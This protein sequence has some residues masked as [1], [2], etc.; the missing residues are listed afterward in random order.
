[1]VREQA[2]EESGIRLLPHKSL[3]HPDAVDRLRERRRDTTKA[4]LRGPREVAEAHAEMAVRT[5]Q[6]RRESRDHEEQH[7]VAAHHDN[8]R[9]HHLPE[10]DCAH[11]HHVLD[12]HPQRLHVTRHATNDPAEFYPVEKTH[13]LALRLRKNLGAQSVDDG[14]TNLERVT[15]APMK[16]HIRREREHP[17]SED[18]P[19]QAADVMV[20]D[21]SGDDCG[22]GPD[23]RRQLRR[24]NHREDEQNVQLALHRPRIGKHAP[25][26]SPLEGLEL[27]RILVVLQRAAHESEVA[28]LGGNLA[29]GRPSVKIVLVLLIVLVLRPVL[30]LLPSVDPLGGRERLRLGERERFG[31]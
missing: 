14:L 11:E 5:P 24:T 3:R 27:L 28:D 19:R 31:G 8:R 22:R 23:Q 16:Q 29:H 7:P 18:R 13:R 12:A 4:L 10:L 30:I 2:A 17:V 1:M 20:G 26:Q 15:L 25:D 6:H 21:R 9:K